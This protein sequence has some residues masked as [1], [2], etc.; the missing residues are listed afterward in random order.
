MYYDE[1]CSDNVDEDHK[2]SDQSE[3][4]LSSPV[5]QHEPYPCHHVEL[6]SKD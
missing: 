6:H 1:D 2:E 4:D 5:H 3:V